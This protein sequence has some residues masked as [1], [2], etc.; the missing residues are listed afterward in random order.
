[1]RKLKTLLPLAV[2]V[3]MTVLS[4]IPALGNDG[5]EPPV[6]PWLADS[7]WAMSHRNSYCQAS[8]PYPG[9]DSVKLRSKA[10]FTVGNT[11]LITIAISSPYPDGSR[12][13]WGSNSTT[14]FKA[15]P[16]GR[17]ITYIDRELK[18]DL[19]P[20]S[21]VSTNEMLSGAYT[22]IDSE[23]IFYVPRLTKLYA[24]GDAVEGDP[25]SDV[26]V[27]RSF[28]I[29]ATRLRDPEEKIVGMNMTY[30]G[31]VAFVTSHG[32]VG[33][34]SRS[35]ETTYF[36]SFADGEEIS[37]SIAC[38]EDGGIYVVTSEK[39]YRVQWTGSELTTDEA[40][41]GWA[42]AYETGDGASGVRLGAGSG[43]T[44]TLM[45]TGD[46]DKFVCI[47]DGMD[48][49]N[50]VIFWRDGIPSDWEQVV[51]TK[52]LRI[53]AQVPVTFG[54]PDTA[55]SMSEQS[56]CIR[57]YGAL[58]VNNQLATNWGSDALNMLLS[59][60]IPNAPYGAEKFEWD[61][62]TRT[63]KTA[64][65]NENVSFPNGIPTMSSAT[66]LMYGVGQGLFGTWTFEA[67]DWSTGES[68]FTFAYGAS[69]ACNSAF[70]ATE[71]GLDG[72]LYTGTLFGIARMRP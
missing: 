32:L 22:V 44:P 40:K 3:F 21:M 34:V 18:E 51:G 2:F 48:L 53:A 49:M 8:S 36:Y 66:N 42:A 13:L 16:S 47:T 5:N 46:Q 29:P 54:D 20:S 65:V 23:N 6:N 63:M 30:D 14:V 55:Y 37:N 45:G 43:S 52:D 15:D 25:Y 69:P 59:G 33:V 68:V 60:V 28:E 7:P 56:V 10:D 19:T 72:S 24:F 11:G 57:G 58:V 50:I 27:K 67:L 71:I 70:A 61:P 31:M 64:W 17:N 12:V 26:V 1:M 4:T 9:P 39:M 35:F 41:G 62:V 38:D